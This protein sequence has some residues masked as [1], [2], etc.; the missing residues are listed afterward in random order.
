MSATV[1]EFV[2]RANVGGSE[3]SPRQIPMSLLRRYTE[4]VETF[5]LGG[6]KS[7]LTE[8]LNVEVSAGSFRLLVEVPPVIQESLR[9]DL[10]AL[11]QGEPLN[12]LHPKRAG[13]IEAWQTE[14]KQ[15]EGYVVAIRD[16]QRA[17]LVAI[18]DGTNFARQ[19]EATWVATDKYLY[20]EILNLGGAKTSNIHLRLEDNGKIVKIDADPGYLRD[21]T[22][23]LVYHHQM[24]HVT[25]EEE[26]RTGE[27]RNLHLVEFVEYN[28]VFDPEAFEAKVDYWTTKWS[29]IPDLDKWLRNLRGGD[30]DD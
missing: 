12:R 1:V 7:V 19:P 28:P 14:A 24:V 5:V 3:V 15:V 9:C 23:N 13:V 18:S 16:P 20:G 11:A 17:Q 25:G 10:Q 8:H 21:L 6:E 27:L 29:T 22:T 30:D 4:Q 2:L 26:L